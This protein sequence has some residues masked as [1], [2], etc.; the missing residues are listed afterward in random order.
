MQLNGSVVRSG[1]EGV[2]VTLIEYRR[3]KFRALRIALNGVDDEEDD[4]GFRAAR[5]VR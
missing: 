1:V 5:L 4:N 3:I 2:V